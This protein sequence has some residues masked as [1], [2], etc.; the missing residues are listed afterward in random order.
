MTYINYLVVVYLRS[1]F[2]IK[3]FENIKKSYKNFID[4]LANANEKSFG[5]ST[6]LDCCKLNRKDK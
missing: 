4:S 1:D 5:G 2:M 6:K 3:I